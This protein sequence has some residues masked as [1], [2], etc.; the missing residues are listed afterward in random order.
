M[1]LL[2]QTSSVQFVSLREVEFNQQARPACIAFLDM[3]SPITDEMLGL[4]Y[5]P[6]KRSYYDIIPYL[7]NQFKGEYPIPASA[8]VRRYTPDVYVGI[9]FILPTGLS[10]ED[11]TDPDDVP[12]WERDA[13]I[14]KL[15]A[16]NVPTHQKTIEDKIEFLN[17]LIR[18][19]QFADLDFIRR[20]FELLNDHIESATV[21]IH[22]MCDEQDYFNYVTAETVTYRGTGES[23]GNVWLARLWNMQTHVEGL[24]GAIGEEYNKRLLESMSRKL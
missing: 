23:Q 22:T 10:W 19:M 16:R 2:Q 14:A 13:F 3:P 4:T 21:T 12:Y 17:D 11:Q 8:H 24:L 6:S 15:A 7:Y 18:G 5:N 20:L 1:D 9:L